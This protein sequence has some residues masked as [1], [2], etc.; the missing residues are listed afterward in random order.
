MMSGNMP[1]GYGQN[2]G[3]D[4]GQQMM[5]GDYSFNQTTAAFPTVMHKTNRPLTNIDV[6][7]HFIYM[8]V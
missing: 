2:V 1:I 4:A 5:P 7:F 6:S 8:C 3:W